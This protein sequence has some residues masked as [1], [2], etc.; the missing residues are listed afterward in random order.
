MWFTRYQ[1]HTYGVYVYFSKISTLLC[2]RC[3]LL[4]TRLIVVVG[5]EVHVISLTFVET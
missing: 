1:I 3:K 5:E 2:V 4:Q